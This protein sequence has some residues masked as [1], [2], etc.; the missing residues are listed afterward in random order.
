MSDLPL[1]GTVIAISRA[2]Y[3]LLDPIEATPTF[4]EWLCICPFLDS[5][6]KYFTSGAF[7]RKWPI[8][9][10]TEEEIVAFAKWMLTK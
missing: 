10:P 3:I 8:V 5:N 6:G 7:R 4:P 9:E 1:P 2:R